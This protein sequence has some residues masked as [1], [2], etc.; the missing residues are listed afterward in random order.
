MRSFI[1]AGAVIAASIS[2]TTADLCYSGPGG[3]SIAQ[4]I[5]PSNPNWYC[6][7]VKAITYQGVGTSGSYKKVTSMTEDGQC[8]FADQQFSGGMAPLAE[9][10]SIHF[11]GPLKLKQLAV[12][13][14]GSS[15][16]RDVS[17]GHHRRHGHQHFHE[18][19][20]EV[21]EVQERAEEREIQEIKARAEAE[22]AKRGNCDPITA[23]WKDGTPMTWAN[24]A[25]GCAATSAM[26]NQQAGNKQAANV[27]PAAQASSTPASSSAAAS[28]SAS[29]SAAASSSASSGSGSS[30]SSSGSSSGGGG[31]G[32]YSRIAYYSASGKSSNGLTFFNNRGDTSK[33][34]CWSQSLGNSLSY[35]SSDGISAASQPTTLDDCT[36]TSTSEVIVM[37]DK[38]YSG[39]NAV[40]PCL[41]DVARQ[42]FPGENAVFL[43]EFSMPDDG[44]SG[45]G[46]NMPAIWFLNA[47]VP[48]TAQYGSCTCW[49]SCGEFD[50]FEVLDSG[51]T[52]AKTCFHGKAQEGGVSDYFVRPTS[53]T[54]KLA[55]TLSGSTA[56]V[57]IVDDG[58]NFGSN[59]SDSDVQ[60]LNSKMDN[61]GDS[62]VYK[63][64]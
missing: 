22:I 40:R 5:P 59:L 62:S 39:G 1:T 42:G 29:S 6:A 45:W 2:G 8:Q 24:T 25:P 43:F 34:G 17:E 33:S 56:H 47:N 51:N 50:I 19:G 63:M 48:R 14:T 49:P 58:T 64:A 57:Q 38:K 53:N 18:H 28:S 44:T 7:P 41:G 23:T 12:Y 16:K 52:R 46:Q 54:I 15:Q 20:K 36:I 11:R 61:G 26:P 9:E 10:L 32:P 13:T 27:A 21:R 37:T 31:S 30:S 3:A 60:A 55:V 35:A 4:N